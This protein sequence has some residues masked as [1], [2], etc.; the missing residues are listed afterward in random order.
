MAH[1]NRRYLK[2]KPKRRTKSDKIFHRTY[3]GVNF[4]TPDYKYNRG[5]KGDQKRMWKELN[6]SVH[7]TGFIPE[8]KSQEPVIVTITSANHMYHE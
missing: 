3:L 8:V 2:Q 5:W 1:P 7:F 4:W 6:D